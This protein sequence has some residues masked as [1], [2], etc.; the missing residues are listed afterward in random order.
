MREAD[1]RIV[2]R[3]EVTVDNDN[4]L[5]SPG[6]TAFARIEFG[7]QAVVRTLWH[8]SRQLLRQELWLLP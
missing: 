2:Y 7:R 8:K 5:L 1:G 6:M 3:V 4:G